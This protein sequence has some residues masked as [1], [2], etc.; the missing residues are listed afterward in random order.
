MSIIVLNNYS[1]YYCYCCNYYYNLGM[2][3]NAT[4]KPEKVYIFLPLN[5]RYSLDMHMEMLVGKDMSLEFWGIVR[6]DDIVLEVTWYLQPCMKSPNETLRERRDV[7]PK[8]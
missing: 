5:L 6:P 2:E 1:Y 4:C 3:E 7:I 8:L